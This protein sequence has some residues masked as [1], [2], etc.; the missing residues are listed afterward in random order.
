[1]PALAPRALIAALSAL[2]T[3]CL[4]CAC[5]G[6]QAPHAAAAE[7][8]E[9]H[10]YNWAD[11]IG[12]D[13]VAQFEAATGIK[14]VYDTYDADE[15]LEAKMMAGDSG[16]DVVSTSTDFFSRQIKAGIYRPLD[17]S[18]LTNWGNLDPH[19]LAVE[20]NSDPG[21][22]Y[23]MP[24][25]RHVN[26]FAYNVDMIRARM[27][28]APVDSLDMVFKPEVI[29]HFADCGVTFLDQP[30]DM[31][32]LALNYLH[33][34]PNSTRPEDYA[35][36]EKLLLTVR[37]YVRAFDSTEYMNGLANGEFCISMSWSGDYATSRARAR[38]AGVDV[39]LA[40]TVPKEG[41]NASYDAWL[42]PA[43]APHP[44]AAHKF[45]NFLLQPRVIAA[46]TNYIHYGNDNRAADAFVDPQIL[47]DPAVYPPPAVEARLYEAAEAT[48]ALER[49]RTRTWTRVKTNL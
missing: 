4:V 29:K 13:T 47:H 26:G 9:L 44:I 17:K 27:P 25:L 41:A 5:G 14:V 16:Y 36:A 3:A 49:L 28:D 10:V 20:A 23:A 15:T 46:I 32:Q 34:D 7:E 39:H 6:G 11:Y 12:K 45:L 38:A 8:Q 33:L 31:L 35:Q 40:F 18:L 37:P 24:Y 48:P 2:F 42:I 43:D 30:E 22:R 21:N 1:M 19:A